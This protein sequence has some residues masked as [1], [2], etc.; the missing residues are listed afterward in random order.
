[1]KRLK[2]AIEKENA[3]LLEEDRSFLENTLIPKAEANRV[4]NKK[5][6]RIIPVTGCLLCC[7][8]VFVLCAIFLFPPK[9]DFD[10]TYKSCASGL[11]EVNENL[12]FTQMAG[13]YSS[14]EITYKISDGK[15]VSFFLVQNRIE[16]ETEI[17]SFKFNLIIDREYMQGDPECYDQQSEYLGYIL[18]SRR[19]VT[20]GAFN[21]Y[22]V[23]SYM[24]T[25]A[26]QYYIE[27]ERWTV[28]ETDNFIE[29][30][31]TKIKNKES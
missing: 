3:A 28:E 17:L 7:I 30:L 21:I 8:V 2:K 25:G 31:S 14:I 9:N 1:M 26:E 29:F 23:S 13:E 20:E 4:A 6:N 27:Y 11:S 5:A 18:Y 15:A 24:D 10:D 12:T 16:T 19:T 22:R